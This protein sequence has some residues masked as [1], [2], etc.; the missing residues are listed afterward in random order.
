LQTH[1]ADEEVPEGRAPEHVMARWADL[2]TG[3]IRQCRLLVFVFS[4]SPSELEGN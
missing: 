4:L 1:E 2:L 3:W